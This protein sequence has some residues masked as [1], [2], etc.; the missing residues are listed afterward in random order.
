MVLYSTQCFTFF[1]LGVINNSLFLCVKFVSVISIMCSNYIH[2]VG[3]C[4][5]FCTNQINFL[6]L[7]N[8]KFRIQE[9]FGNCTKASVGIKKSKSIYKYNVSHKQL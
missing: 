4:P 8:N 6:W 1:F 2:A 3:L 7:A 9:H 5:L